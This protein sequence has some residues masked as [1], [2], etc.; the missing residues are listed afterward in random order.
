MLETEMVGLKFKNPLIAGCAGITMEAR[1]IKKWLDAGAGGILG[2]TLASDPAERV[3]I[4]PYFYVLEKQGFQGTFVDQETPGWVAPDIWAKT[5]APEIAKLCEDYDARWIQSI[6]GEGVEFEDWKKLARLVEDVGAE[7]VEL[8]VSCP[9]LMAGGEVELGEDL[10]TLATLVKTVKDEVSIPV[11]V[12]LTCTVRPIDR[13]AKIAEIAGADYATCINNPPGF[14]I[15]LE[16]EEIIGSPEV[17]GVVLGRYLKFI[18][19]YKVLQVK[20]ACDFPVSG[21]GGIWTAQDAIEYILLGCPTFQ[22]VTSIYFKGPKVIEEILTGITEFMNTK[23]YK[24]IDEFRG[25]ILRQLTEIDVPKEKNEM[26]L[27][28]SPLIANIDVEKC[29]LCNK[30]SDSCIHDA[31]TI[32]VDNKEI[33][34]DENRCHG[35]GFCVGICP[36]DAIQIMHKGTASIVWDGKGSAKTD[37]VHW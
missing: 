22:M 31:I 28:P 9:V 35:C 37:W 2:K 29:I 25:K 21:V 16:K 26:K 3:Y 30:C 11:G 7:G 1:I 34:V 19:Q 13:I 5:E 14:A 15:D 20:Q 24:N 4:R 17:G 27:Y 33:R 32:N 12:K 18:G 23:G 10:P 8:D 36:V 6:K